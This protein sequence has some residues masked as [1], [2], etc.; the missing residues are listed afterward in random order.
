MSGVVEAY[1]RNAKLPRTG[2]GRKNA[3]GDKGAWWLEA[4]LAPTRVDGDD[5][6]MKGFTSHHLVSLLSRDPNKVVR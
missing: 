4:V 6:S 2:E 5:G 3:K 1:A